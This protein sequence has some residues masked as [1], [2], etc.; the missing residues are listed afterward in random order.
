M[1]ATQEL[2]RPAAGAGPTRRSEVDTR[3]EVPV[4]VTV[5]APAAGSEDEDEAVA[6]TAAAAVDEEDA[7]ASTRAVPV[8]TR[9]LPPR[10][11]RHPLTSLRRPAANLERLSHL[12]LR[13]D[14]Y[15]LRLKALSTSCFFTNSLVF[16]SFFFSCDLYSPCFFFERHV[17]TFLHFLF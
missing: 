15:R 7:V 2:G 3:A 17:C 16:F 4:T 14:L 5:A 8:Q 1:T 13:Y 6:A 11:R 9:Q 12:Y 10:P